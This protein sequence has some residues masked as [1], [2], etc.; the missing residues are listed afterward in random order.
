[1][2]LLLLIYGFSLPSSYVL[3]LWMQ[4]LPS[5]PW[6]LRELQKLM[7]PSGADANPPGLGDQ[8][9]E[10]DALDAANLGLSLES[11]QPESK[12]R[13]LSGPR[14]KKSREEVFQEQTEQFTGKVDEVINNLGDAAM[15]FPT[16]ALCAKILR[17]ISSKVEEARSAGCFTT[18]TQLEALANKLTVIK[19]GI[20]VSNL[21]I[22]PSGSVKKAHED[23]FV[24]GFGQVPLAIR[25]RF[26]GTILNRWLHLVHSKD[27]VRISAWGLSAG[28]KLLN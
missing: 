4:L 3:F 2:L 19:E 18:V 23:S 20:R 9:E 25:S 17:G 15:P 11:G 7:R 8:D 21:Y 12:R 13:R 22:S 16:V 1:M 28:L 26:P 10:Q 14:I 6:H 24:K 5:L 27:S